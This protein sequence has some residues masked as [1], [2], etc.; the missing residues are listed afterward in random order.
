VWAA[1]REGAREVRSHVWVSATLASFCVALFCGLAPWFVLGPLV[2]REQY[3]HLA[4]YGYVEAALG[5]GTIVGSV[6]GVGWRPRYPMRLAMLAMLLWPVAAVLYALGVTLLLVI[7]ATALAGGGIALFDVWWLTALAERIPPE[8]LS[9]VTS[10][11]WMVSYAL[12]PL[13]Y[14]L[15][16]PLA[17]ALGAVEVVLGGSALAFV[18]FV[19]GLVPRE[20]RTL[21]RLSREDPL[22]RAPEP[23]A[24][25]AHHR[26]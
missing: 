21:K 17:D 26:P 24:A 2:A 23:V 5:L 1:I 3:G 12:L 4:V 13:G 22:A 20:T 25:L 6:V 18:A 9:R 16:G 7:P 15:A 19:L 8:K 14:V 11:D 10:Y